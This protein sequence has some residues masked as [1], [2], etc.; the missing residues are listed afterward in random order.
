MSARTGRL[1]PVSESHRGDLIAIVG[2]STRVLDDCMTAN[3]ALVEAPSHLPSYPAGARFT[4]HCRPGLDLPVAL[5]AMDGLNRNLRSHLLRWLLVSA[6]GFASDGLLRTR[7]DVDGAALDN[8][9]DSDGASLLLSVLRDHEQT[10]ETAMVISLLERGGAVNSLGG[11]LD[12]LKQ[13]HRPGRE[14]ADI[15]SR[16]IDVLLHANEDNRHEAL[17]AFHETMQLADRSGHFPEHLPEEGWTVAPTPYLLSHMT[18][19]LAAS[20]TGELARIPKSGYTGR[21]AF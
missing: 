19:L 11:F 17:R 20:A 4:R 10:S 21:R 18:F 16:F 6:S 7:Y 5:V 15:S 3:G 14:H 2:T 13:R 12:A 8:R 9:V 1:D